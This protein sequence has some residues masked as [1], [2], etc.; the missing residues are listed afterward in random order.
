V[1]LLKVSTSAQLM[2]HAKSAGGKT[3]SLFAPQTTDTE[4][5]ARGGDLWK[6]IKKVAALKEKK[7]VWDPSLDN[8]DEVMC[9]ITVDGTNFRMW[10]RKH[11]LF[12]VSAGACS[13]KFN[14]RATKHEIA[15]EKGQNSKKGS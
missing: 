2:G 11:N 3:H 10:E 9:S 5:A 12:N 13:Q 8:P 6:W 14:H 15:L 7:I 1:V 4:R